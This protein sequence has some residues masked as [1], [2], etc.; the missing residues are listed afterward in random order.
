MGVLSGKKDV[1]DVRK[2]TEELLAGK[3][4]KGV[5]GQVGIDDNWVTLRHKGALGVATH[6]LPGEKRIPIANVTAVTIKEPRLTN[7]YIHF[8]LLGSMDRQ[9]GG[10]FDATRD[11]NSVMFSKGHL[12][13]F[14]AVKEHVEA[15]IARG[16]FGAA[17][18]S[19][20]PVPAPPTKFEQLKQLG[21]LRTAGVLNAAEFEAE[22]Q[23]LLNTE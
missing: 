12:A 21:D 7:G 5:G 20:A 8:S 4:A 10:V 11:E 1:E 9:K 17:A 15:R 19:P 6:G 23:K 18:G 2:A 14:V 13:E 3:V 22:K 16:A